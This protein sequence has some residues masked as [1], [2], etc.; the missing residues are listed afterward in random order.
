MKLRKLSEED[1]REQWLKKL[2]LG[3]DW[4]GKFFFRRIAEVK[5]PST[6]IQVKTEQGGIFG[7]IFQVR[8]IT[9]Q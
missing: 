3:M 9:V 4:K 7:I 5:A 2:I 6:M 8:N 1:K